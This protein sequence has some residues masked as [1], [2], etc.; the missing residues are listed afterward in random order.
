MKNLLV[1]AMFFMLSVAILPGCKALFGEKV[2][3][4]LTKNKDIYF[5]VGKAFGKPVIQDLFGLNEFDFNAD[6]LSVSKDASNDQIQKTLGQ[7]I[8]NF[9]TQTGDFSLNT[10]NFFAGILWKH[11]GIE[12]STNIS[13]RY[14]RKPKD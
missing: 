6:S 7:K 5:E 4:S 1:Y 8:P 13:F 9:L 10:E 2:S 11:T 12:G 14:Y 3:E